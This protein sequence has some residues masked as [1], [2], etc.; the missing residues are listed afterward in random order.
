MKSLSLDGKHKG[1]SE[2]NNHVVY[3]TRNAFQVA[4]CRGWLSPAGHASS[5]SLERC[6]S[7]PIH[8][9]ARAGRSGNRSRR[10][11]QRYLLNTLM[12]GTYL[13]YIELMPGRI[14]RMIRPHFCPFLCCFFRLIEKNLQKKISQK[15]I[16]KIGI[17]YVFLR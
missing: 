1:N 6:D 4:Y 13:K 12:N 11:L 9:R 7:S 14:P 5:A 8:Q 16:F 17:S 3:H 10:R 2:V 15:R